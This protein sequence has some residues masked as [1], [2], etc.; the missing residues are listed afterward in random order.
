MD[1]EMRFYK[2]YMEEFSKKIAAIQPDQFN[3]SVELI[4][5]CNENN[6]K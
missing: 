4:K 1:K 6:G 3:K 5:S 2:N